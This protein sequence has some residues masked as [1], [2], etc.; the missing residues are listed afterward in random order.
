MICAHAMLCLLLGLLTAA[1]AE[2]AD[3]G[4]APTGAVTNPGDLFKEA[5]GTEFRFSYFPSLDRLRLLVLRSPREFTRWEITLRR[6]GKSD[7]LTHGAGT[8]PMP[9][10]V[11]TLKTPSLDDVTY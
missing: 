6:E 1:P 8:L 11:E 5:N 7:A 2:G 4:R 10:A 3:P 9:A